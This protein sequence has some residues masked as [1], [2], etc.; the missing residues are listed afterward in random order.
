MAQQAVRKQVETPAPAPRAPRL[1]KG[2]TGSAPD[3]TR[4]RLTFS[5]PDDFMSYMRGYPNPEGVTL[6]LYRLLPKIDLSLIGLRESNIQKGGYDDL[7]LFGFDSVAEKFGRGKYYL[8]VTD[9][10]RPEGQREV[11]KSATYKIA[12][13]EKPPVYDV[14]TLVLSDA[15][16]IDE[17]NRLITSGVLIRDAN[18][19]PRLRTAAD[20]SAAPM[21]AR[22][23]ASVATDSAEILGGNVIGQIVLAALN[24]GTQSPHDAV[25]DTIEVARLLA[26]PPP[27]FDMDALIDRLGARFG[28]KPAGAAGPDDLFAAYERVEGFISKVRGP[29]AGVNGGSGE[30][31]ADQLQRVGASFAPHLAGILHEGRLLLSEAVGAF[32]MLKGQPNGAPAAPPQNGGNHQVA[33]MKPLD[34]R[35]EEVFR[36]GF[37]K[38]QEGMNGFDFAAWVCFHYQGGLEVYRALEPQGTMGLI[39]LAAMNPGA[40]PI[41]NNPQIRPQLEAFLNDFFSFDPSGNGGAPGPDGTS[42]APPPSA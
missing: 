16:N 30:S 9:S 37:Q 5:N 4:F 18:G 10:N 1:P 15:E 8:K 42:S 32:V 2:K 6:F 35:I 3:Y 34:A 26:P 14:R 28:L 31:A 36:F 21:P 27:A 33:Q 17:V 39:S 25:K 38:M 22:P 11:V 40:A 41:V 29:S 23:V 7:P 19:A 20:A 12:D 13:A 24:R